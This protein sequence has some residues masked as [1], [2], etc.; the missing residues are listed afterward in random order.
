MKGRIIAL[1]SQ[2]YSQA[3]AL[4]KLERLD[5]AEALYQALCLK[6]PDNPL[7]FVGLARVA[8]RRGDWDEAVRR[9]SA[10]LE[11]FPDQ[12]KPWWRS[13]IGQA[14]MR[15]G[16][17]DDAH[18]VYDAMCRE[19]PDAPGGHAGLAQVAAARSH[20]HDAARLWAS[21][22]ATFADSEEPWWCAGEANALLQLSL[23]PEARERF[24]HLATQWPDS[25]LGLEGL[26]RTAV[27]A[28]DPEAALALARRLI[29]Q[30]PANPAGYY[31][32]EEALI[33]LGRFEE[34]GR[35][36]LSGPAQRPPA[37]PPPPRPANVP[38]ELT[39]PRIRGEGND[40]SFIEDRLALFREAGDPYHLPV[41]VIIPT[42]NRSAILSKTL[43]ALTHQTYPRELI[44]VVISD[45]GSADPIEPVARQYDRNFRITY[46][47]QEDRGYRLAAV[48]N[49]GMRAASHQHFV[50]LDADVLPVPNLVEAYM[51][52]FHVTDQ[53]VLIGLRRYVCADELTDQHV[54]ADIRVALD[55]PDINPNNEVAAWRTAD[56]RVCDWR[57]PL[58]VKTHELKA[59]RYPFVAL[60]GGNFAVAK[61][62][63]D[64][65][66]LFDEEFQDWGG[67]DQELGYRLYNAG[68]YFIP[69]RDAT[70][71][72]QEPALGDHQTDRE[73]GAESTRPLLERKC[74][75][76]RTRVENGT[77]TRVTPKVS[78]YMPAYNA[79]RFITQAIDSA[80]AQ[81]FTDLEVVICDD[82]S[83]DGT[84]AL[85]QAH[86]RDNP[87]VRW[88]SQPH[89]GI[90][91]ASNSAI[92]LCRGMYIGQLDADDVLR[93][94]AI[95]QAVTLLDRTGA[96]V[97]YGG[98]ELIDEDDAS[99]RALVTPP[100]S[101]E[102]MLVSM[103]VRPFRMFRKRDWM[104]T[105][106]FDE[107]LSS[108]V[109]HDMFQKLSEVCTFVQL[110][111]VTYGYRFHGT[112]TSLVSRRA[113]EANHLESTQRALRR[114][115][116][117]QTWAVVPAPHG[118][119][120]DFRIERRQEDPYDRVQDV[121]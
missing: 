73:T 110:S 44:E 80:L 63:L 88:V 42:F 77:D 67:E 58:L 91:A 54:L 119:S 81:S 94:G 115:G 104:R 36:K 22:R 55:L 8:S 6:S 87:R 14:L 40:Y 78:I 106:G 39:L 45:D 96:G 89:G 64:A 48:R 114:M 84:A 27:R 90:S 117:A 43:A 29:E 24:Q 1:M 83:T 9:W 21:C 95:E 97:A 4:L 79:E 75:P 18:A 49:L 100:F 108:A 19:H 109:D 31:W 5:E 86:Y 66:G 68:C 11:R 111:G 85:L 25:P 37:T 92:R 59:H 56:G 118:D 26:A 13:G 16:R 51:K 72:H 71:L 12:I 82:G 120:K 20:W 98:A 47:R 34:A 65:A 74:P 28:G 99:R 30:H 50:F 3:E 107:A 46:V 53:A 17:L 15:L 116:L 93:P 33:N 121:L 69:V 57:L 38:P 10:C 32:A 62:A 23:Y 113:Q 103:I 52:Y 101:R 60:A 112:N 105:E 35:V 61:S 70:G 2:G 76:L 7:G 102:R 41:S